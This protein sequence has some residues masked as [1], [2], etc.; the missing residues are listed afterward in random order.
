MIS[1]NTE[2]GNVCL[3]YVAQTTPQRI[4]ILG[5]DDVEESFVYT[6]TEHGYRFQS[7]DGGTC[8]YIEGE[9]PLTCLKWY[10]MGLLDLHQETDEHFYIEEVEGFIIVFRVGLPDKD[11]YIHDGTGQ[12]IEQVLV[13][14]GTPEYKDS[15][16]LLR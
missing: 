10:S 11:A 9:D 6:K 3:F 2:N 5:P 16:L 12:L 7:W 8:F 15:K 1:Y 13:E 4:C 14:Y